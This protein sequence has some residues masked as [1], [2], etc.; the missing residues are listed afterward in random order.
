MR[1][2]G[3]VRHASAM[4]RNWDQYGELTAYGEFHPDAVTEQLGVAPSRIE[5]AGDPTQIGVV[6]DIHSRWVWRTPTR[7]GLGAKDVAL[8]VL[9]QF[10]SRA[11]ALRRLVES[12]LSG[13]TLAIVVRMAVPPDHPGDDLSHAPNLI[14][15]S[16]IL[17]RMAALHVTLGIL[18]YVYVAEKLVDGSDPLAPPS[19]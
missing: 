6:R 2:V 12:E 13:A 18:P 5:R 16:D 4:R 15:S 9:D 19:G 14:F 10:E 17:A 8:E 11:G 7:T 1:F 3:G